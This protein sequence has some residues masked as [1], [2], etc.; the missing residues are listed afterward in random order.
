MHVVEMTIYQ[1][2]GGREGIE[3]LAN[4][5]HERCLADDV[6]AHAFSHGF[7]PEHTQ[8]LA[9]YWC[10]ALGGPRD[11]SSG[12][13]D[14]SMVIRMHAGNGEHQEMDDRA[15]ACFVEALDDVG[16]SNDERLRST[17]E[18]YFRWSISTMSSFPNSPDDV[19]LGRA[20]ARWSWDGPV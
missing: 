4:A 2:A 13:G 17:L 12:L 16:L 10:E 18:R 20:I 14:E 7:H 9:A 15:I 5:W 8:R 6:V 1:A 3:A 19:P 11:Y